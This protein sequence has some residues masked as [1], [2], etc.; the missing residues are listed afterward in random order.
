MYFTNASLPNTFLEVGVMRS[1]AAPANFAARGRAPLHVG[2]YPAFQLDTHAGTQIPVPCLGRVMLSGD[3]TVIATWCAPDSAAHRQ[4][5]EAILASYQTRGMLL[6][7]SSAIPQMTVNPVLT[8]S[9]VIQN[10][11]PRMWGSPPP[12]PDATFGMEQVSPTD[13][14]WTDSFG[15]G[16]AV[17]D[18]Y[19]SGGSYMWEN[20]Y[21]FQCVELANRFINEEWGLTEFTVDAFAYYD[22]YQNGSFVEGQAR[23]YFG[24]QVQQIDDASQGNNSAPPSPGDLLIFQDV[25]NGSNWTSGEKCWSGD[26]PCSNWHPGHVAVVTSVTS[27]Q[28]NLVQQNFNANG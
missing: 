28:V 11:G 27:S 18:D 1:P 20:S 9:Q 3:D 25:N 4:Q 24:S 21:L 7:Q 14:T 13:S 17:C 22:S 6:A 2:S 10:P 23:S 15:E 12:L 26:N 19:Y 16:V 8:C 5:F